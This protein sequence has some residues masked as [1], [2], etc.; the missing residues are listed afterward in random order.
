MNNYGE[1]SVMTWRHKCKGELRSNRAAATQN[2]LENT[3]ADI[4]EYRT[5]RPLQKHERTGKEYGCFPFV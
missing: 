4:W 2:C 5:H 1:S 3:T